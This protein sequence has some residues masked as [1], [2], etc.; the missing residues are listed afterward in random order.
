MKPIALKPESQQS[1]PEPQKITLEMVEQMTNKAATKAADEAAVK[2][3]QRVSDEAMESFSKFQQQNQQQSQQQSQR[4]SENYEQS[5]IVYEDDDGG[6]SI[7]RK[8]EKNLL[9][10]VLDNTL[11][12]A[13]DPPPDPIRSAMENGISQMAT[14]FV[15]N[16]FGGMG[17][18]TVSRK[19]SLI[20]DI[21]NTAAAH[22]FGEQ[23]GANLPQVINSLTSSIGQQKA[24]ELAS[25]AT[26]AMSQSPSAQQNNTNLSDSNSEKQKDMILALDSNNPEHVAQYASAMGLSQSAAKEMLQNHQND[27]LKSRKPLSSGT[28]TNVSSNNE[29]TQAL[30][31]LIQ[32]MTGMKQTINALQNEIVTIKSK[33]STEVKETHPEVSESMT[34]DKWSDETPKVDV[35]KQQVGTQQKSVNLFSTPIKV[36][37]DQIKGNS[38]PFFKET[39]E[40]EIEEPEESV[41]EE[42]VDDEGKSTF[43]MS[44]EQSKK[45]IEPPKE[46]TKKVDG[47]SKEQPKSTPEISIETEQDKKKESSSTELVETE[48]IPKE[49]VIKKKIIRKPIPIK[50]DESNTPSH[51][52]ERYD[53]NNNLITPEDN[54]K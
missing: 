49:R 37:V 14:R 39:S 42:I 30:T 46:Q 28:D 31:V 2:A 38:D 12:N 15:E 36:D 11:K 13:L 4:Q 18:Q 51:T 26:K 6:Y 48:Q 52:T 3:A 34:D 45:V 40:D 17:S 7:D 54:I 47:I 1:Q 8:T 21:L 27:I 24:Q 5:D 53:I 41:L 50:K 20:L 9:R 25:A 19:P 23:L 29:I 22:G 44:D 16:A 10:R 35:Y 43:K 33:T 32:E